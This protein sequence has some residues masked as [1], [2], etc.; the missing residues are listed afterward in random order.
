[1][2]ERPALIDSVSIARFESKA[3][4]VFLRDE[5]DSLVAEFG[6]EPTKLICLT[7]APLD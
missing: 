7:Y 3:L 6:Q 1:M 4:S 5:D 2:A